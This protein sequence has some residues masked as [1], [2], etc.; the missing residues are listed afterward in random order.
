MLPRLGF[1][2]TAWTMSIPAKFHKAP[3][4]HSTALSRWAASVLIILSALLPIFGVAATPNSPPLSVLVFGGSGQ[5]GSLVVRAALAEGHKVSVFARETSNMQR[6]EG[7]PVTVIR[8]DVREAADVDR[9][10]KS[11]SFDVVVDALGRSESGVEFYEQAAGH[12]TRAAAATRVKHLI[13]HGSVGAGESRAAYPA[14]LLPERNALLLS[15]GA[16]EKLVRDSGVP[17]TIIRNAVLRPL[18]AGQ[19]DRAELFEDPLA[20]GAVSREGVAR[21][22]VQCFRDPRCRNRTFHAIDAGLAYR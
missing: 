4:A 12:I 22:T 16:A 3:A 6:L 18:P 20:F 17:Y 9:A 8:G 5:L 14:N 21:L 7:L 11:Q 15:K 1:G 19:A 10:L 2:Y 13:H